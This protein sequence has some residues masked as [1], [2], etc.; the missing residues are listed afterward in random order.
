MGPSG[1]N[2]FL[3]LISPELINKFSTFIKNFPL[4]NK[5]INIIKNKTKPQNSTLQ[6]ALMPKKIRKDPNIK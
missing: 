4:K 5:K 6:I 1:K 3:T 2:K